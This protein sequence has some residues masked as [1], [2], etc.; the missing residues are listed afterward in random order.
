[1]SIE[2]QYLNALAHKK[3][4]EVK[5]KFDINELSEHQEL[6]QDIQ[7]KSKKEPVWQI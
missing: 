1:M 2:E 4:L 3:T 7:K 5:N 6:L